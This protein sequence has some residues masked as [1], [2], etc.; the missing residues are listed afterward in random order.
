MA[1]G[2]SF[3]NSGETLLMGHQRNPTILN[4][5]LELAL[6]EFPVFR[7][8]GKKPSAKGWQQEATTNEEQIRHLF[9]RGNYNVAVKTGRPYGLVVIDIDDEE[10]W[11]AFKSKFGVAETPTLTCRT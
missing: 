2:R 11:Q 6:R 9:S 5:A 4:H 8:V 1:T 10:N 3:L 7:A